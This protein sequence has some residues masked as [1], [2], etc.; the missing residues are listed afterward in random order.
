MVDASTQCGSDDFQLPTET[1][2]LIMASHTVCLC[3]DR[4]CPDCGGSYLSSSQGIESGFDA[5]EVSEASH[6]EASNVIVANPGGRVV[7]SANHAETV[8]DGEPS[9]SLPSV[10][11][12]L[13][14]LIKE[15]MMAE[16]VEH[17]MTHTPACPRTCEGCMAKARNKKHYKDAFKKTKD[18]KRGTIT[19]DQL[20]VKDEFGTMGIGGYAYAIV[21]AKIGGDF[22]SFVPLRTLTAAE[23]MIAFRTFCKL[24]GSTVDNT[25]VYSDAHASLRKICATMGLAVSHPPPARAQGNSVVERRVGL[26]LQGIRACLVIAG[27]PNCFCLS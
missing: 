1:A 9:D 23:A 26:S 11:T 15:R 7:P 4:D 5:H 14:A 20:T 22:W 2:K 13:D 6:S 18:E 19:M 27:F 10:P 16:S 3:M 24:T 17:L 12:A 21:F 25:I 8:G